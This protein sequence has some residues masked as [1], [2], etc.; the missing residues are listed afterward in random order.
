MLFAL[1]LLFLV[2]DAP[3]APAYQPKY[4]PVRLHNGV[5]FRPSPD[6]FAFV[7]DGKVLKRY[8]FK[9]LGAV[10]ESPLSKDPY[11]IREGFRERRGVCGLLSGV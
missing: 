5:E 8:T 1:S 11:V 7:K 9:E 4:K 6:G 10:P 2:A 3:K